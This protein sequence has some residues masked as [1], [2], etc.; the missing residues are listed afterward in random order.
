[1]DIQIPGVDVDSGLDLCDGDLNIYLR[2]L[3]AYVSA[4]PAAL[5]KMQNV[6]AE[7]LHNYAINVHGVKSTST[8]IGAEETRKTAR[9][10]EIMA[11]DGDLSGVL[12]LNEPFIKQ[13]V[14]LVEGIKS[15]LEKY[16]AAL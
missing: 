12:S 7:T 4:I 6:T 9:Q 15:W 14:S 3:R 11:N 16:D 10:L 8:S 5:E 1:M 13:T 2:V